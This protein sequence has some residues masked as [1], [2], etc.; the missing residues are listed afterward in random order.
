MAH[1][2]ATATLPIT[3]ASTLAITTTSLPNAVVGKAYSATLAATGGTTPYTWSIL[4]G[5]LPAGLVLSPAGAISGTPTAAGS[6]SPEFEVT[7][8]S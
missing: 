1:Q 7:D 6:S 8:N 4:T 5:A 3:V 2:T